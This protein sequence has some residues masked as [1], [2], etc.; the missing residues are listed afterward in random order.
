MLVSLVTLFTVGCGDSRDSYVYNGNPPAS[1]NTGNLT[2]QFQQQQTTAQQAGIVPAGTTSL[3]FEFFSTTSGNDTDLVHEDNVAYA[4]Q[5]TISGVPTSAVFVRVTAYSAS[6]VP[7]AVFTGNFEVAIGATTPVDL[8]APTAVTFDSLTVSP[9]TLALSLAEGG[10]DSAPLTLVGNFSNGQTVAFPSNTFVANAD[11]SSSDTDVATVSSS[12]VVQAVGNGE[13]DITA[14]YTLNGVEQSATTTVTVTGGIVDVDTLTVTPSTLTVAPDS[15]SG[16]LSA[17]FTPAGGTPVNVDGNV[18]YTLQAAVSGIEVD[19]QTGQVTVDDGTSNTTTAVVVATYSTGNVTVTDTVAV[20]V[21]DVFIVSVGAYGSNTLHYPPGSQV[22]ALFQVVFSDATSE[23]GYAIN[24]L[25]SLK[26]W[27]IIVSDPANTAVLNVTDSGYLEFAED[28]IGN[29]NTTF[30]I[31]V[32]DSNVSATITA[33]NF[34]DTTYSIDVLPSRTRVNAGD[35]FG[36]QAV[37]NYGGG[38]V[39]DISPFVSLDWDNRGAYV[40]YI[41]GLFYNTFRSYGPAPGQTGEVDFEVTN[42]W[43]LSLPGNPDYNDATVTVIGGS[44]NPPR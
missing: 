40:D 21:G 20:N 35:P 28:S 19:N 6:G 17:T 42:S 26:G 36:V 27:E 38:V 31:S 11:F 15:T 43:D 37:I 34:N 1:P 16:P 23:T 12:G 39:Q 18:T 32:V 33:V 13:A 14:T 7:L 5:V 24:N 30:T 4:S 44:Y 22:P 41:S 3:L 25:P 9:A 2:F 29:Q 10:T 8:S